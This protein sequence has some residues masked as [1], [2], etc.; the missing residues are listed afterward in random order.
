[1]FKYHYSLANAG[2]VFITISHARMLLLHLPSSLSA[3]LTSPFFRL[4]QCYP[5][6]ESAIVLPCNLA[7]AFCSPGASTKLLRRRDNTAEAHVPRKLPRSPSCTAILPSTCA[8]NSEQLRTTSCN[9][10]YVLYQGRR[11]ALQ[12]RQAS[13]LPSRQPHPRASTNTRLVL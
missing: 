6:Q 1:M 3:E 10:S 11:V 13:A 9:F 8:N 7:A 5:M 4:N 12:E 2:Y